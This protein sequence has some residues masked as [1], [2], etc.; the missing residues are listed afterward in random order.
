MGKKKLKFKG[1]VNFPSYRNENVFF[2]DGD[3]KEVPAALADYLLRDFSEYFVEIKPIKKEIKK[4][5]V[6]R[7]IK[8]AKTK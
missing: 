1:T 7:M 3:V 2:A 6:H 5:Q 4:P 8:K